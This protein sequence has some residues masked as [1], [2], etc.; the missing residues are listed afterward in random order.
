M[1]SSLS[2]GQTAFW[3][4][5]DPDS[6]I[7]ISVAHDAVVTSPNI[8]LDLEKS[9][10]DWKGADRILNILRKASLYR[11][12]GRSIACFLCIAGGDEMRPTS[13]S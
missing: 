5:G 9:K 4:T 1:G 8:S 6:F 2:E 11:A 7:I 12:T 3:L 10:D 13:S